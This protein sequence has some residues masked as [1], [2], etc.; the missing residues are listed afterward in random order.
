MAIGPR[1][2]GLG[3][4]VAVGEEAG[5]GVVKGRL[6]GVDSWGIVGCEFCSSCASTV[7]EVGGGADCMLEHPLIRRMESVITMARRLQA[8]FCVRW[9]GMQSGEAV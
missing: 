4:G 8:A 2:N 7:V 9:H 6:S 3:V 5:V 1:K